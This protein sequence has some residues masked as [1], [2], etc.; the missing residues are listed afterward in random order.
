MSDTA[1]QRQWLWTWGG[2][3]FG[4]REGDELWAHDGRHVGRFDADKIYGPD[5]C[6]LGEILDGNRLITA[7]F[8]IS[9]RQP[10][11]TMQQRRPGSP[12]RRRLPGYVMPT[13]FEDVPVQEKLP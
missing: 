10:S 1:N 8:R 3:S 12:R 9:M 7:K 11:F 6:Y 13:G 5:G 2:E 4:Y